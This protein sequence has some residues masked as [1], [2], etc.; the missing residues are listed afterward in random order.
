MSWASCGSLE[1]GWGGEDQDPQGPHRAGELVTI[2]A[3]VRV[4]RRWPSPP[5][6]PVPLPLL[7]PCLGAAST[8]LGP[9]APKS[10]SRGASDMTFL[11]QVVSRMAQMFIFASKLLL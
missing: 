10:A 9:H 5:G 7:I 11:I 6:V 4:P 2:R 3:D 8:S 1:V